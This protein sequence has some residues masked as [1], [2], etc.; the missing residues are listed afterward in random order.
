MVVGDL[1]ERRL[2]LVLLRRSDLVLSL[3]DAQFS[4]FVGTGETLIFG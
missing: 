3:N 1:D 2:R 4:A